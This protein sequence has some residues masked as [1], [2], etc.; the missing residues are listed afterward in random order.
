[1][2]S[3]LKKMLCKEEK[4]PKTQKQ[5]EKEVEALS[6]LIKNMN[7]VIYDKGS[8]VGKEKYG[9]TESHHIG[10]AYFKKYKWGKDGNPNK[11]SRERIFNNSIAPILKEYTRGI[12]NDNGEELIK[13]C[14]KALGVNYQS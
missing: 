13:E 1:M 8:S 5:H 10:P 14:A 2:D 9:L 11:N 7:K 4:D 6:E 3:V 12:S